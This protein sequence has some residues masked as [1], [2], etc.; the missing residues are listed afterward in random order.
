MTPRIVYYVLTV[1][2]REIRVCAYRRLNNDP[3][4]SGPNP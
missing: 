3:K 1:Y 4:I 2:V